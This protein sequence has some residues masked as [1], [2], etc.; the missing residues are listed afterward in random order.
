MKTDT[1]GVKQYIQQEGETI[2]AVAYD[3][4]IPGYNTHN[5]NVL[6]LWRAIPT[7]VD[8][9]IFLNHRKSISKSLIRVIT[10][11]H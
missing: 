6:R 3:T 4:P 10:Q 9:S 5:C 11:L 2:L 1:K 7:D 8:S